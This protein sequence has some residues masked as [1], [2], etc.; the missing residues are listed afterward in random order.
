MLIATVEL[1]FSIVKC[2][3]GGRVISLDY[4][5][6]WDPRKSYYALI[7]ALFILYVKYGLLYGQM[8]IIGLPPYPPQALKEAIF[9]SLENY[10]LYKV[11]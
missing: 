2:V 3:G 4:V 6:W 7:T 5:G 8:I 9:I 11:L 10:G 1:D